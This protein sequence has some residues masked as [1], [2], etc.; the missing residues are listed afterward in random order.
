VKKEK[1][2]RRKKKV[3]VTI[4]KQQTAS[5]AEANCKQKPTKR[6]LLQYFSFMFFFVLEI[7]ELNF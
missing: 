4:G 7:L 3:A 5:K 2:T 1:Y 6:L